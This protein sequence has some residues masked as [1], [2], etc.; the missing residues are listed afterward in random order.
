MASFTFDVGS[1]ALQGAGAGSGIDFH[2]NANIKA[3]L[4]GA[5]PSRTATSMS[6]ITAIGTDVSPANPTVTN[7][8][9]NHRT[10]YD[11][12]DPTWSAVAGGSTVTGIVVYLFNSNDAGSTPLFFVAAGPLA[13]NGSDIGWAIDAA[14]IAYT[15]A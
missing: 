14:G 1:F 4:V 3:R 15:Q 12:D 10:V 8:T 11:A 9:T 13:T 6:G 5:T 7:D 2:A